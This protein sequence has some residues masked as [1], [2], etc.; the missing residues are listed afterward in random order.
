VSY[1]V[2]WSQ[3]GSQPWNL[4][5]FLQVGAGYLVSEQSDHRGEALAHAAKAPQTGTPM[6]SAVGSPVSD[7]SSG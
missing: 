5:L 4:L 1:P 2:V 6:L 3:T 7:S